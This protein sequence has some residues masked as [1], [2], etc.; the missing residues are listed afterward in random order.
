MPAE[1]AVVLFAPVWFLFVVA[2]IDWG[3]L[4]ILDDITALPEVGEEV[5]VLLLA[6]HR[7]ETTLRSF[8]LIMVGLLLWISWM[9][10]AYFLLSV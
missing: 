2:D 4:A 8:E 10:L 5:P 7:G 1:E 6:Q 9:E 3:E